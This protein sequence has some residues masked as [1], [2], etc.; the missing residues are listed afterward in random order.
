MELCLKG[1]PSPLV[2]SF[3]GDRDFDQT[4]FDK[5][6]TV[7]LTVNAVL[8]DAEEKQIT[9]MAVKE[10]VNEL[11]D[12]AYHAEDLLDEIATIALQCELEAE[13]KLK[14]KHIMGLFFTHNSK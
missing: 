11:K 13:A 6:K 7:L 9:N 1:W 4:L 14:G 2:R 5:M 3:F 12:A 8:S 10:W